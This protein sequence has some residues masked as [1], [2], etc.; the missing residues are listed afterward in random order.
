MPAQ[1]QWWTP[2]PPG[3]S[4]FSAPVGAQLLR[5]A[6]GVLCGCKPRLATCPTAILC[7]LSQNVQF[8]WPKARKNCTW[9]FNGHN[10]AGG[11]AARRGLQPHRTPRVTLS[12]WAP[13]GAEN[14]GPPGGPG[15]H[16][17]CRASTSLPPGVP[18]LPGD[19]WNGLIWAPSR[20]PGPLQRLLAPF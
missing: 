14:C 7:P 12:S 20:S 17:W 5:A 8:F 13:T 19:P 15:L 4:K 10:I 11:G 9:A 6:R 16:H 2:G 3:G 18:L 1:H